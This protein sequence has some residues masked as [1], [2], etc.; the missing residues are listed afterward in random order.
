MYLVEIKNKINKALN[1]LYNNDFPLI[2]NGLCEL[3]INYRFSMYLEKQN[4]GDG[5]Y[6]DCEYNKSRSEFQR[7][8]DL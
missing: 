4:F 6:V 1:D 2:K 8:F 3:C 7:C 5:Y